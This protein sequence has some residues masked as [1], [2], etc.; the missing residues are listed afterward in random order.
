MTFRTIIY[1]CI[2][3]FLLSSCSNEQLKSLEA[4]PTAIGSTNEIV[5]VADQN[6]WDGPV[7]DSLR[8]YFESPYLIL[9]QPEPIFDLRH[10]TMEE[11]QKEPLRKQLR[12]Y[13]LLGDLQDDSSVASN[14]IKQDLRSENIRRAKED[15]T[16]SSTAGRNKWANGQLLVYLFGYGQEA[17]INNIRKNYPVIAQKVKNFDR[18]QIEASAYAMGEN[19]V[20]TN[21]LKTD[22]GFSLKMPRDFKIAIEDGNFQWYRKETR[23]ASCNIMLYK[24]PYTDK[25]Q[26]SKEG[27]KNIRNEL[28]KNYITTDIEGAYMRINDVDLPMFVENIKLNGQFGIEA[29]GI[30][31][32]ENDF[33]GGP[34]ISYI[35][36][37]PK[38]NELIFMDGFV[39]APGK[40]KRDFMQQLEFI[41]KSLKF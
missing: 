16:F 1:T 21:K 24:I 23:S 27:I 14:E 13:M 7:G 5:I 6:V 18:S 39:H 3:S 36:L 29:R 12:T 11:L 2:L 22:L 32:I 9:P 8:Y 30:W 40:E 15:N 38:T 31:D 41:F 19:A 20:N 34:F 28:G 25:A 10:F 17:L 33:M 4:L 26:L 37:N 35:V